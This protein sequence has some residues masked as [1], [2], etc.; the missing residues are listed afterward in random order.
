MKT[1]YK[2]GDVL[3]IR[4][5]SGNVLASDITS[6][7]IEK[8]NVLCDVIYT[9]SNKQEVHEAS[10]L[11]EDYDIRIIKKVASLNQNDIKDNQGVITKYDIGDILQMMNY[12]DETCAAD[13]TMI[14]IDK[15]GICYHLSN[16][17]EVDEI[18]VDNNYIRIVGKIGTL[19][20]ET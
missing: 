6:I 4:D 8:G 7:A 1:K 13:I 9:L 10:E 3:A 2:I 16:G 14:D 19:N 20:M 5:M 18:P 15:E 12:Y 11:Y 17:D